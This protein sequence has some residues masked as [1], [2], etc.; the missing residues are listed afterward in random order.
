MNKEFRNAVGDMQQLYLTKDAFTMGDLRQ[1]LKEGFDPKD[2][3][4]KSNIAGAQAYLRNMKGVYETYGK[5]YKGDSDLVELEKR[6]EGTNTEEL[7]TG[8]GALERVL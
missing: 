8:K 4:L 5:S 7:V 6:L 3:K 1:V 2:P